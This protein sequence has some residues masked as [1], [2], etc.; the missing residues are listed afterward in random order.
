MGSGHYVAM[1][2][3]SQRRNEGVQ[4]KSPAANAPTTGT[5][6]SQQKDASGLTKSDHEAARQWIYC[7]DDIVRPASVDE[8]FKS[9]AY[10]LMY[11]R[12]DP[13]EHVPAKM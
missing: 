1:T 4:L 7:S 8:V 5:Q 11:E 2:Y 13:S 10:L 12:V 3:T 6:Q 9:Q